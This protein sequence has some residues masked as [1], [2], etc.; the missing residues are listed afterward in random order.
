MGLPQRVKTILQTGTSYREAQMLG[1]IFDLEQNTI[2]LV[3]DSAG[4][5]H[6]GIGTDGVLTF[7]GEARQSGVP[8]FGT[9]TFPAA[10]TGL[11]V[12]DVL[13]TTATLNWTLPGAATPPIDAIFIILYDSDGTFVANVSTDT[14]SD[15]SFGLT[16]LTHDTDYVVDVMLGRGSDFALGPRTRLAFTSDALP[17]AGPPTGL[18]VGATEG[19]GGMNI[20]WTDPA[21][22]GNFD[23]VTVRYDTDAYPATITDGTDGGH[24]ARGAQFTTV[25]GLAANT[26][27]FFAL[28]A[29]DDALDDVAPGAGQ[30]TAETAAGVAS[31]PAAVTATPNYTT[32]DIVFTWDNPGNQDNF[33]I[34]YYVDD[35]RIN[36]DTVSGSETSFTWGPSNAG[37][38]STPSIGHTFALRVQ[39]IVGGTFST[40]VT[41]AD[42]AWS[43]PDV[44]AAI[45]AVTPGSEF[46]LGTNSLWG[47][48]FRVTEDVLVTAIGF[49]SIGGLTAAGLGIVVGHDIVSAKGTLSTGVTDADIESGDS[50]QATLVQPVILHSGTD[51]FIAIGTGTGDPEFIAVT[52][53]SGVA[54]TG[55][56]T[57]VGSSKYDTGYGNGPSPFSTVFTLI[58]IDPAPT[59]TGVGGQDADELAAVGS[60]SWATDFEL[61]ADTSVA[62]VDITVSGTAIPVGAILS[63][64]SDDGSG[65]GVAGLPDT[66]IETCTLA[67]D[68]SSLDPARF[69]FKTAAAL[70]SGVH[71]WL[72][73][74]SS[75]DHAGFSFAPTSP[76]GVVSAV[77]TTESRN[78]F[79]GGW[80]G[81]SG[82]YLIFEL[83]ASS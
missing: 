62:G 71:Y 60:P 61:N 55:V 47:T 23:R 16:G 13:S 6:L 54:F 59:Y 77:G 79:A 44:P 72:C 82:A 73:L 81:S 67:V 78:D 69:I 15:T 14:A 66:V 7:D 8:E 21:N 40:G 64:R 1:R 68:T 26:S 4:E 76:T 2:V 49:S 28:F 9:L 53:S 18:S 48:P 45:G 17:A 36:F 10:V 75:A 12:S 22:W 74:E 58:G 27:Y 5:H 37:Y 25:T 32:G 11:H 38:P 42:L 80:D 43:P 46:G 41:S 83:L 70:V 30:I 24:V 34:S 63:I 51:Y 57:D 29:S 35:S 20:A 50:G 19:G 65:S 31:D 52:S 39:G 3:D 56:V 33:S